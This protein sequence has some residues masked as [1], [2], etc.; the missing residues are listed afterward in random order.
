MARP[1]E[2]DEQQALI[3]AMELFWHKGY[4]ATSISDLTEAM[5]IQRP[6]LYGTF[7]GKEEL[8]QAAIRKYAELSLAYI[9]G[10]LGQ[11]TSAREAIR[12]YLI[13]ITSAEGGRRP[14]WGCLCVNA[15]TEL[16]PHHSNLA[17][18]TAEFQRNITAILKETIEAGIRQGEL[19]SKLNAASIAAA[20]SIAAVGLAVTMKGRPDHAEIGQAIDQMV[21]LLD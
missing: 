12:R 13:G 16:A 3:K 14:E 2:F 10:K 5:G 11:P 17:S 7:G 1:R 4:E 8:F 18:F 9:R 20:L 19:S 21:H 15:M 6:S